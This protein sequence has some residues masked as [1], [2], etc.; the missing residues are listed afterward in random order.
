[1]NI[2]IDEL[3]VFPIKVF[4]NASNIFEGKSIG[5]DD[6]S[7]IVINNDLFQLFKPN[8]KLIISNS[9][10]EKL[11]YFLEPDLKFVLTDLFSNSDNL[12]K[13]ISLKLPSNNSYSNNSFHLLLHE[14][15]LSNYNYVHID[16][17]ISR[18]GVNNLKFDKVYKLGKLSFAV[19]IN[20][21][22]W[23]LIILINDYS[24]LPVVNNE[25]VNE[26][27]HRYDT[28]V[29][30]SE[31]KMVSKILLEEED[32]E[33]IVEEEKSDVKMDFEYKYQKLHFIESNS[34]IQIIILNKKK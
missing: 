25:Y 1:M 2:L 13:L 34:C 30:K 12:R 19:K 4:L 33:E 18:V 11:Y 29:L 9:D 17:L 32:I 5:N 27:M 8:F 14:S 26:K 24:K 6:N 16:S 21:P 22:V 20:S 23:N 31:A 3:M 15:L 10:L 28:A 7:N